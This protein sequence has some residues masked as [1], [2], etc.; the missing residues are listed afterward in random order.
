MKNILCIKWGD[1][2][3]A[4]YVN[5][6][7]RMVSRHITPP[8]RFVC[9]TD[10][11]TGIEDGIET[12]PIPEFNRKKAFKEP[13]RDGGWKKLLTFS[14]PL[15]DL[16]GTALFLDLDIVIVGNIDG[17]FEPKGDFFIIQ[18]WLRPNLTG[19]SSVYRFEIGKHEDIITYFLENEKKIRSS[20]RN[21]QE[22]LSAYM[23]EK[24]S[25]QYWNDSLVKSFKRHCMFSGIRGWLKRPILPEEAKIIVFHGHPTPDQAIAGD[26]GK[27]FR[28][29]LPSKWV[30]EHWG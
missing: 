29:V 22:F 11:T 21:E 16:E 30:A 5:K 13:K 7:Y 18:D 20:V 12:F 2:Y 17:F 27:W 15:Y 23:K 3:D 19:N 14:S 28:K 4:S 1:K 8:Y 24:D 6:L 10:D 26:S 9:L 25:L